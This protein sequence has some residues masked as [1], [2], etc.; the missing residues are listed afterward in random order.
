MEANGTASC[1]DSKFIAEFTINNSTYKY[2][3][4]FDSAVN[5][6]AVPMALL[7]YNNTGQLDGDVKISA[8]TVGTNSINIKLAND[9]YITGDTG[10]SIDETSVGGESGLW[11][12]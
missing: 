3:V 8:G 5:N 7:S 1:D 12:H 4:K 2:E 9:V 10:N 6:F 11:T